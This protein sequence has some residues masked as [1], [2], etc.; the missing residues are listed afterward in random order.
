MVQEL[1]TELIDISPPLSPETAVWPGDTPLTRQP[2]L[3]IS[4]GANIDLSTLH[5]TVH[6]GA[7]TDAYS[8]IIA[9]G[10]SIEQASLE[11][12]LGLCRVVTILR[13]TLIVADDLR[14]FL[15]QPCPRI[16]I[17]TS[18]FPDWRNFNEQFSAFSAEAI[19][20]L[21]EHGVVLVGIDT[22]SIDPFDSK[23]LPAH[24]ALVRNRMVNLEGLV[25][26]AVEDGLYELIALP[27]KL[28][29]FDASPVRAV[30]RKHR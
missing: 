21:A 23:D 30:L 2:L 16:L 3:S 14:P 12:Y 7:H 18:S 25:L 15:E 1:M 8:H 28:V 13:T 6:I 24:K 5:S 22:P 27:L 11:P 29:G 19:E 17:K 9:Q 20:F 10:P 26:D 4:K